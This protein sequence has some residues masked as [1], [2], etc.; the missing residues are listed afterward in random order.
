MVNAVGFHRLDFFRVG[1]D[2]SG[3]RQYHMTPLSSE[4][5]KE[6]RLCVLRAIGLG[7]LTKHL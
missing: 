4:N 3:N 5:I 2:F 7:T 6:I 1:K